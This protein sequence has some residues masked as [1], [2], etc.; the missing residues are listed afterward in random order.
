MKKPHSHDKH[1]VAPDQLA[2][3]IL[4]L[5]RTE[6]HTSDALAQI[7]G[8]TG[9]A[10]RGRL[11]ELRL[12]GFVIRQ[13]KS[14]PGGGMN[15]IWSASESAGPLPVAK[16]REPKGFGK[17]HQV[18][19]QQYPASHMRDPLVSALFGPVRREAA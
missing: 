5:L 13:S 6:P 2:G 4:D 9:G 11:A 17:P 3:A 8:Y 7:T 18:S 1:T 16:E 15:Y 10:V 14:R 12:G 19:R